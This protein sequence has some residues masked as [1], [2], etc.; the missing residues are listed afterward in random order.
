MDRYY[1]AQ[2]R[3]G[4]WFSKT[5]Q[6]TT[7]LS[8]AK[9]MDYLEAIKMC[10]LYKSNGVICVPVRKGDMELVNGQR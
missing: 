10:R 2:L 9:E 1:V 7:Q 8:E 6:F 3:G 4:G 5:S